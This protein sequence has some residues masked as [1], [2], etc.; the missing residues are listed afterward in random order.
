MIRIRTQAENATRK[1]EAQPYCIRTLE[2]RMAD[3]MR[4][5]AFADQNVSIET[6]VQRGW[7]ESTISRLHG[8]AARIARRL[9]VRQVA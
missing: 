7:T 6:L 4:E 1:I 5:L 9:S 2:E 8:D 3:D